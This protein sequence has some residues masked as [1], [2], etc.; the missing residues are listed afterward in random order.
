[1]DNLAL[2]ISS[3]SPHVLEDDPAVSSI[4]TSRTIATMDVEDRGPA[5][6]A[7]TWILTTVASSAVVM[8]LALRFKLSSIG[9][10]D[11]FMC[12][13]AVRISSMLHSYVLPLTL[14]SF[15]TTP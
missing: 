12:L 4:S 15:S 7:I 11:I 5:L 9:W 3:P 1:M 2:S 13:A 10:D 6:A 14:D 8:R